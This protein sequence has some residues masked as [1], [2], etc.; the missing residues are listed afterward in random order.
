MQQLKN[1]M[2]QNSIVSLAR[3]MRHEDLISPRGDSA[4]WLTIHGG[5]GQVPPMSTTRPE[6][7]E[8]EAPDARSPSLLHN[9]STPKRKASDDERE[10]KSD[11]KRARTEGSPNEKSDDARSQSNSALEQAQAFGGNF[12]PSSSR[13][14]LYE[15]VLQHQHARASALAS[16]R[17]A[18]TRFVA[19]GLEGASDSSQLMLG[20]RLGLQA[21]ARA[22][23]GAFSHRIS[24][25]EMAVR[26]ELMGRQG[27]SLNDN[28]MED[29]VA[30]RLQALRH[31]VMY[32]YQDRFGVHAASFG[33][34][35][36]TNAE[37]TAMLEA[38]G[39]TG[40]TF[41]RFGGEDEIARMMETL[42]RSGARTEFGLSFPGIESNL[43]EM[44]R[45]SR[46]ED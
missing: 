45:K 12:L 24:R 2:L 19:G 8:L 41:N 1:R 18:S 23:T 3:R 22:Q 26:L 30:A 31:R 38:F 42:R 14:A 35:G 7:N 17:P 37:N 44:N 33:Q 29:D 5:A 20:Y 13:T 39:R 27:S 9:E 15:D 36:R 43:H 32:Q 28:R 10:A 46:K 16:L 25:E 4:P 40:S 34:L 21:A 6:Q 11:V